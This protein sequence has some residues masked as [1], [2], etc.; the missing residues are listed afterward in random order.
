M[1]AKLELK[2]IDGK[3]HKEWNMRLNLTQRVKLTRAGR[4]KD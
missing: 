1:V 2:R 4:D 3:A